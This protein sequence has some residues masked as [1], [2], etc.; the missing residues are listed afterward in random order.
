[1]EFEL[2]SLFVKNSKRVLTRE[3]IMESLRGLEWEAYDRSVDVLIS[4]LRQKLGDKKKHQ[5][6]IKTIWGTGYKF[7][8]DE[9]YES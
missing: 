8:G 5:R 2:L 1:M 7:V 4:R 6:Y 3:N 9:I